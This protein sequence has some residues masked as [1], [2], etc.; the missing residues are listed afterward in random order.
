MEINDYIKA[1][2]VLFKQIYNDEIVLE[3]VKKQIYTDSKKLIKYADYLLSGKWTKLVGM[4][5][6]FILS[7]LAL[8]LKPVF[9]KFIRLHFNESVFYDTMSDIKIWGED[10]RSHHNG[11]VGITE[12]NWLHL[13]FEC[14]IFKFGRLQYQISKYYFEKST[15]IK[16]RTIKY[17]DTIYNI[18]IPRGAKLDSVSAK[19]SITLAVDT[20]ED[21]FRDIPTD[22]MMC[23]SWLLCPY[24]KR[25]MPANSN[26][27]KFANMFNLISVSG[28]AQQHFRWIFDIDEDNKVFEKSKKKNGYYYN[29]IDFKPTTK[30]QA[31]CKHYILGGGELNSGRGLLA[32]KNIIG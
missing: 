11:E 14:Q 28:G 5:P 32:T 19:K 17:G 29:L 9:D 20:L 1:N 8:S 2:W 18:H 13:H 23:D 22:I 15:T 27:I 26:I 24:N 25:F 6:I 21:I 16:D 3:A 10:Y 12:I 30:M 4:P 7:T 31:E